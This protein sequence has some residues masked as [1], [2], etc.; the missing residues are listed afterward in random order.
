M[1]FGDGDMCLEFFLSP[2]NQG[3]RPAGRVPF[4]T[5]V[6]CRLGTIQTDGEAAVWHLLGGVPLPAASA[7]LQERELRLSIALARAPAEL[8]RILG[9]LALGRLQPASLI[10]GLE[11]EPEPEPASRS[12][13]ILEMM[14]R[15]TREDVTVY[16][17]A[18]AAPELWL[19]LLQSLPNVPSEPAAPPPAA[20]WYSSNELVSLPVSIAYGS[21]TG[22]QVARL[23]PGDVIRLSTSFDV[24][25][26]GRLRLGRSEF[27]VCWRTRNP[28][29]VFELLEPPRQVAEA[30]AVVEGA[31]EGLG[32]TLEFLTMNHEETDPDGDSS[33]DSDGASN[34]HFGFGGDRLQNWSSEY[35]GLEEFGQHASD[36]GRDGE[37]SGLSRMPVTLVAEIGTL[38]MTLGTL[39]EL[40]PG[41]LIKLASRGEDEVVLRAVDGPAVAYAELV[42]IG[43]HLGMQVTRIVRT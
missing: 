6:R 5:A 30:S 7:T 24:T 21:L 35:S 39:S 25:G 4:D 20:A 36:A 8:V 12:E 37:S 26:R 32:S 29:H 42:D 23:K 22:R 1:K 14:W 15:V 19:S 16:A 2:W 28:E 11:N 40:K 3:T 33:H 43:G 10:R 41:A 27:D 18:S 31:S 34:E 9:P 13:D 17:R 38:T